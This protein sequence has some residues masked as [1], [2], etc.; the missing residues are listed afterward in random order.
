MTTTETQTTQIYRIAI[1]AT[2]EAI[3][4]AITTSEFTQRFFFGARHTVTA[5]RYLSLSPEGEVW[6]D[7]PVEEFDPPRRLVHGWHSEYDEELAAEARSRVAW[8]IEPQDDGSCLLTLVHDRL[9]GAPKTAAS[10]AGGWMTV[11]G[12]LKSLLETGDAGA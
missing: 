7:E 3:W 12:R 5:E 11:L 2:P 8:E 10:V 1:E 6:A 4:E 9:E